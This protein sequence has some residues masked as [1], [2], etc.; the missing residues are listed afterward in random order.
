MRVRIEIDNQLK[1]A[2]VLIKAP[3]W[4]DE[5]REI[6]HQLEQSP[7]PSLTFYKGTGQYFLSL[8]EVLFF[9]TEGPRVYAHTKG[10]AYEVH[11][12]LYELEELLPARFS[13]ISKSTIANLGQIYSIEKSFS[14][15]STLAFY[16]TYKEVHVSRHYY[17][18][19]KDK[20]KELR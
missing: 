1:E 3:A 6:Y 10:E 18:S 15:T 7:S 11:F 13:R 2:E 5:V 4:T 9:E 17:H 20:I 16:E 12:K 14:G 19:V 8:D